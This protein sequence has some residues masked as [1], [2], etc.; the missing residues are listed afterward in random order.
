MDIVRAILLTAMLAALWGCSPYGYSSQIGDLDKSVTGLANSVKSGH[1]ALISDTTNGRNLD[2]IYRQRPV[3]LSPSCTPGT[4]RSS[5]KDLPCAAY[6]VGGSP[7]ELA[8]PSPIPPK[9]KAMLAGLKDY[10]AALAAVTK[11]SDR[12]D[13]TTAVG[14][15][16]ASASAFVG[17]AAGPGTVVAPIVAA[18]INLAGWL[19]GTSL[20]IQRFQALRDAVNRVDKPVAPTNE[21]PMD[22][23]AAELSVHLTSLVGKRRTRLYLAAHVIR[24][25]L[26]PGLGPE[27]YKAR[28][29][30]LGAVLATY[31]GLRLSDPEG[32]AKAL[33]AAHA[34][35]VE[36]VN[37]PKLD[38]GAL[39][40]AL[41]DLKDKVT[42]LETAIAAASTPAKAAATNSK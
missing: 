5:P 40:Q 17:A 16:S 20:D 9:L 3:A 23:F 10:T 39:M 7:E 31:E 14:K 21:K 33:P 19:V 1:E 34:A 12:T 37:N 11:A 32:A 26:G 36:A 22:I 38:I 6:K 8:D 2:L 18:G 29:A 13:F 30:D 28:L 15:L 35:L 24:A 42:A 41:G 27:T 4:V 25:E